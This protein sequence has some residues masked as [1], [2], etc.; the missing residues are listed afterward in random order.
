[1]KLNLI[2]PLVLVLAISGCEALRL[3]PNE[4]QKQNAWLHYKA[5][6]LISDMTQ[7]EN[8][9]NELKP[10]A[11]LSNL[12]SKAFVSYFG[13]P[14]DYPTT[15]SASDILNQANFQL[16]KIATIES[17]KRPDPFRMADNI[18]ELAIGITALLGGVYGAKTVKFLKDVKIKSTALKEIVEGNELFKKQNNQSAQEFNNSHQN[19]SIQTK[20]IVSTIKSSSNI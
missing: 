11:S 16:A 9:T 10:L 19:Q 7:E 17:A 4:Q 5:T 1:M 2:I 12:Q 20:H 18:L 6:E 14:K 15:N 8:Y 3:A 13:L